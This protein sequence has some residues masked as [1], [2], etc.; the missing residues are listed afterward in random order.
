MY[1]A[2][3][4]QFNKY[5]KLFQSEECLLHELHVQMFGLTKQFFAFFLK[6]ELVSCMNTYKDILKIDVANS[7]NYLPDK[8][9]FTGVNANISNKI[10]NTSMQEFM[11]V[12]KQAYSRC[13]AY[14][15][16]KTS[17]G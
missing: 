17:L 16:K 15:Q 5:V 9:I 11:K 2:V 7:E 14:M 8:L 3:L 1:L 6:H 13:A 4:P 10:S 12:L